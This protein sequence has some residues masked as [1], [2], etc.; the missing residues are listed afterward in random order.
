MK[1]KVI[2]LTGGIGSGK[3]EVARILRHMGYQTVDCDVLAREIA[4]EHSVVSA[5]ESLLGS[6]SVTNGAINRKKV[7]EMVF[8]DDNLLREYNAIFHE[9]IR[10]RLAELVEQ[11]SE[12][13]FVEI[14]LIEAFAFHFDEIW[15]IECMQS[16]RIERVTA[17]DGVSASNVTNIMSK[18][19]YD[20]KYTRIL[21]NN[22][23]LD[24]LKA[25]VIAALQ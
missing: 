25:Q 10:E 20:G 8:A 1:R 7:R 2:A 9:R 23:S 6:D 16:T 11:T 4:N 19:R 13:L 17:R 21:T 3:S 5:V 14:A 22:G 12:T 15:L 18:Q 24:E